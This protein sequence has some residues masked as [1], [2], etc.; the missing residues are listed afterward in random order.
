MFRLY[1]D[2]TLRLEVLFYIQSKGKKGD[3][4]NYDDTTEVFLTVS[5]IERSLKDAIQEQL[6]VLQSKY[7]EMEILGLKA[8]F[9][10][11]KLEEIKIK[12][13]FADDK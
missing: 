6:D 4:M 9:G 5:G 7:P 13:I 2:Y 8:I 11:E 12:Y 10:E 3:T 1:S